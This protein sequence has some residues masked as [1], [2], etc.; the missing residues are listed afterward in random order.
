MIAQKD[1]LILVDHRRA[2]VT[3]IDLEGSVLCTQMFLPDE[4]PREIDRG[5]LA[6]REPGID[7]L[8]IGHR[9]RRGEVVLLMNGGKRAFGWKRELPCVLAA[10]PIECGDQE[11]DFV[12]ATS[13]RARQGP[14]ARLERVA[15][16]HQPRAQGARFRFLPAT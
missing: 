9:T 6:R 15:G 1:Q 10:G 5:Y 3:P 4:F 16:L 11:R 14:L 2:A 7:T 8:A 12:H 13:R